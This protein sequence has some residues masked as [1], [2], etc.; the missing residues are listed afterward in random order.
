MATSSVCGSDVPTPDDS[1]KLDPRL[2][3]DLTN[4]GMPSE[5]VAEFISA[6]KSCNILT[7]GALRLFSTEVEAVVQLNYDESTLIGK[8]K[9]KGF[10]ATVRVRHPASQAPAHV[11]RIAPPR[12]P[13]RMLLN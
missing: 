2:T 4:A 7:Y 6:L 8:L 9:A 11:E 12:P 5:E 10:L 3:N 1:E 13:C